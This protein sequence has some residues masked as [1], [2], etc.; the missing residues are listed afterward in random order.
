MFQQN[1]TY[2]LVLEP[3]TYLSFT[4]QGVLVYNTLDGSSI[5]SQ[6]RPV[7]DL[8]H[9]MNEQSEGLIQ[10]KGSDFK[11][12]IIESFIVKLRD[13]F[14]GDI[15]DCSLSEGSPIQLMPIL[16]L[17]NS[18]ER[19]KAG[20]EHGA[21]ENILTHL[22]ELLFFLDDPDAFPTKYYPT[23]LNSFI[24]GY[25]NSNDLSDF[26]YIKNCLT[27]LPY[28]KKDLTL[29]FIMKDIFPDED[30]EALMHFLNG[31]MAKKIFSF[32]YDD[33]NIS[34]KYIRKIN[35][36]K[37][38]LDI[39]IGFPIKNNQLKSISQLLM[40]EK[41]EPNYVFTVSSEEEM[42]IAEEIIA[43]LEMQHYSLIPVYTGHNS[44]FFEKHIFLS[45]EEILSMPVSMRKIF[46]HKS[47][48]AESFGK[49]II[50]PSGA[51]YSNLFSDKVGSIQDC[52]LLNLLH[53]EVT[54]NY[55]WFKIRDYKPC[56]NC[57]YQ[58]LC[59]SPSNYEVLLNKKNL[60]HVKK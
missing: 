39:Y 24:P 20:Q 38:N 32:R 15:I 48:N 21:G 53:N 29:N 6:E 23:T 55:S 44:L 16:N 9:T 59:P 57:S 43:R 14:M 3:Y 8:L 1:K 42:Q 60:C 58:W 11:D 4:H 13:H 46:I 45:K 41:S 25:T 12:E 52:S 18:V 40:R 28:N 34:E 31:F 27:Q 10:I 51:V 50:L 17:Q 36:K 30:L 19:L 33:E 49:L 5:E 7:V 35:E 47:L 22:H 54:S 37:I 56:N 26:Q 2:W